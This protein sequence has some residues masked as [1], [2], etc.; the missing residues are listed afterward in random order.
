M[1]NNI[2]TKSQFINA[3]GMNTKLK[4]HTNAADDV[5]YKLFHH[6]NNP[7]FVQMHI[8]CKTQFNNL[9][10][11]NVFFFLSFIEYK[12]IKVYPV[13]TFHH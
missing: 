1:A 7:F 13:E 3:T 4:K 9:Y 6:Y 8:I 5:L 12:F 10:F 11:E 2:N